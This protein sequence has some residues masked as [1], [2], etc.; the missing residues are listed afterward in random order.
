MIEYVEKNGGHIELWVRSA[1]HPD[2]AT[3]LTT[4]LLK[5]VTRLREQGRA[6]LKNYP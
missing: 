6:S 5:I 2:G 1:K 3:H 4:P